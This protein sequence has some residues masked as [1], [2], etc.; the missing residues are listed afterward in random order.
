MDTPIDLQ[1]SSLE[2]DFRSPVLT[3]LRRPA[4][5]GRPSAQQVDREPTVVHF[6]A[7]VSVSCEQERIHGRSNLHAVRDGTR[8]LKTI[9]RERASAASV[10][11]PLGRGRRRVGSS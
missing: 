9:V 11:V 4:S 2:P 7:R 3:Q 8:V 1:D 10:W 5:S 6:G